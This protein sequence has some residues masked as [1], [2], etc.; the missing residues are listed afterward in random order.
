MTAVCLK[1]KTDCGG[2]QFMLMITTVPCGR[3]QNETCSRV[4][5]GIVFRHNPASNNAWNWASLARS[6]NTHKLE[7]T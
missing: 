1:E 6:I 5:L 7:I 2:R 3:A 4:A